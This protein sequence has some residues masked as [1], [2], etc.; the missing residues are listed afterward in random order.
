MLEKANGGHNCP[1][2]RALP[3]KL[4]E[5]LNLRL[6]GSSDYVLEETWRQEAFRA[7]LA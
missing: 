7:D 1:K 6:F 5:A 2:V 4:H 3:D